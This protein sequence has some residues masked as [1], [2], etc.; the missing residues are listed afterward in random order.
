MKENDE[1]R[2]NKSSALDDYESSRDHL[3]TLIMDQNQVFSEQI[4]Q[5]ARAVLDLIQEIVIIK[6]FNPF[7]EIPRELTQNQIKAGLDFYNLT[8]IMTFC[9]QVLDEEESLDAVLERNLLLN[10]FLDQE[11]P[12]DY[13]IHTVGNELKN[14]VKIFIQHAALP[15]NKKQLPAKGVVADLLKE[16][17]NEEEHPVIESNQSSEVIEHEEKHSDI[18]SMSTS[19][20]V[21]EK[22]TDIKNPPKH[23]ICLDRFLSDLIEYKSEIKN[24]KN[25]PI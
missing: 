9:A 17:D 16:I 18:Q 10:W 23:P 2:T 7:A 20:S 14:K 5:D 21:R 24:K 15:E 25:L 11:I 3:N 13:P 19:R 8:K 22:W 12:T 1:I 4:K 6:N